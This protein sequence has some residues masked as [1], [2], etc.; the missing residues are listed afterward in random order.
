MQIRRARY[1]GF[2]ALRGGSRFFIT[3][4]AAVSDRRHARRNFQ[5]PN[6]LWQPMSF[7]VETCLW[8]N[9][10]AGSSHAL[11]NCTIFLMKFLSRFPETRKLVKTSGNR[12]V[13]LPNCNL[14]MLRPE[15]P[16]PRHSW[17]DKALSGHLMGTYS[18]LAFRQ[19]TELT[20]CNAPISFW[21]NDIFA[22]Q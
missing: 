1:R 22:Y 2:N 15:G 10:L 7:L 4:N 18:S 19:S 17:E 12:E 13:F 8:F 16:S 14:L 20:W 21:T 5:F 9:F 3:E 6:L 11:Q